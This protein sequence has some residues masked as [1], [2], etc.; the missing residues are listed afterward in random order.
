M[1]KILMVILLAAFTSCSITNKSKTKASE[2]VEI[3]AEEKT[4]SIH[5][6]KV[7]STSVKTSDSSYAD[8]KT[9]S[10]TFENDYAG[11][12]VKNDSIPSKE[13]FY[14]SIGGKEI[15]SSKP[16]K[17][18]DITDESTGQST[19]LDITALHKKD[20]TAV[21]KKKSTDVKIESKKESKDVKKF[22]VSGWQIIILV[23]VA[24]LFY[25]WIWPMIAPLFK[26]RKDPI[27]RHTQF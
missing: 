2:K 6:A 3:K 14:Y 9:V 23:V 26:K 25:F 12:A 24:L 17:S 18:I 19:K 5:S 21:E 20:T 4:D 11:A 27:N 8:K 13:D 10:I 22:R 16:I 7:D 1:N 15:K